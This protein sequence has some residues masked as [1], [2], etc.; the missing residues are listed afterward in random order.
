MGRRLS[1][2]EHVA[3]AAKHKTVGQALS[4]PTI[5]NEWAAVCYF[6][7]AYHL[8]KAALVSDSLFDDMASLKAIDP[9]LVPEDRLAS[10]HQVR[11]RGTGFGVNDLVRLVY[12]S[13]NSAY[14]ELHGQSIGV[15]YER[16]TSVPLDD[17]AE[18][19]AEIETEFK[20]HTD[21]RLK[22][23]QQALAPSV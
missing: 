14:L 12:P 11:R 1:C 9:N 15:R 23:L 2:D 6:Y 7:S 13:I 22:V 5:S 18:D 21:P 16:G 10:K 20:S 19:L 17:L 8:V 3:R 4:D